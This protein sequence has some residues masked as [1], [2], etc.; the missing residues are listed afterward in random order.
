MPHEKPNPIF[1]AMIAAG[2]VP[3]DI[4]PTPTA[5]ALTSSDGVGDGEHLRAESERALKEWWD[6]CFAVSP[7][8]CGTMRPSDFFHAGYA[9]GRRSQGVSSPTHIL[10]DK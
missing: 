4:P 5:K 6:K 8:M 7:C 9:A 3:V 2:A 1:Q 10:G